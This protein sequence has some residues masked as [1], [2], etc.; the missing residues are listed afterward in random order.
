[1]LTSISPVGE[2]GRGQRWP[3]TVTAYVMGSLLGGGLLGA[4]LGGVGQAL[5]GRVGDATAAVIL[6]AVAVVGLALDSRWRGLA[7]PG[8]R[9]QVD[10]TWLTRYRGWVYG[11]GFG[12]QLGAGV[13]TIVA[14]SLLYVVMAAALLTGSTVAGAAVGACFGLVRALPLVAMAPVRTVD[15]LA[16]FHRRLSRLATP[17]DRAARLVQAGVAAVLAVGVLA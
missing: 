7:P 17:A 8:L 4:A 16:R 11:L 14:S 6:A 2:Q 15:V 5:P 13:L 1:M 10:E 9:R 12:F 3:V